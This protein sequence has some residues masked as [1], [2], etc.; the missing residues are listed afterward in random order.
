AAWFAWSGWR[1]QQ[2]GASST[3][4][5]QA[6]DTAAQQ[7]AAALSDSR[8]RFLAQLE[9]PATQAA[10]EAGDLAAA[11]TALGDGW[12]M[13]EATEV[14]PLELDAAYAAVAAGERGYGRLASLEGAVVADAVVAMVVRDGGAPAL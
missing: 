1:Q 6:R 5:Q 7:V 14:L 10:L 2:D 12:D 9:T 13:A 4:L 3:A 11:G 8:E